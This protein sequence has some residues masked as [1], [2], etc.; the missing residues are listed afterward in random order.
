MRAEWWAVALLMYA[1]GVIWG[2]IKIDAPLPSRVGLAFAWPIGPVA[3]IITLT[4]LVAAAAIAF[5]AFGALLAAGVIAGW[6][7]WAA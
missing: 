1:A 5:P 4:V 6:L 2:L 7:Y 3:F